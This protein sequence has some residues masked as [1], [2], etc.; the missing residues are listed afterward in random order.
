MSSGYV[1]SCGPPGLE[2]RECGRILLIGS[3]AGAMSPSAQ[4]ALAAADVVYCEQDVDPDILAGTAPRAFVEWVPA[5]GDR[6]VARAVSV[7]RAC[8]LA[9]DGWR[10]VWVIPGDRAHSLPDFAA[11]NPEI[12]AGNVE[13]HVAATGEPHLLAT[14]LNGLAG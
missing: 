8:K 6:A 1:A 12:D 13:A 2:I 7:S 10:V 5:D 9:S 3:D 11:A 4:A 14:A